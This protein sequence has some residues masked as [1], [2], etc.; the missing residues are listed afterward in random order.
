MSLPVGAD[1]ESIC[2][3]CGDVWHVV[4]AKAGDKIA[5]VVCKRCQGQHRY[6]PPPGKASANAPYE[7]KAVAPR[8][9]R[10]A[11]AGRG[12]VTRVDAPSVAIDESKP[13]RVYSPRDNYKAGERVTHPSFG[14]GVVE[15]SPGT[16]KI[17]I[18]FPVGR[19]ILVVGRP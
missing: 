8:A 14:T 13:P 11:G 19:K 1:I 16:G 2:G 5:K 3:K 18:F 7:K 6:K 17:T 10:A 4:F 12:K 9:P 15:G